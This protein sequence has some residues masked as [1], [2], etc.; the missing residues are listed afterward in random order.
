MTTG[1]PWAVAASVS[2]T[3]Q[4]RGIDKLGE[5]RLGVAASVN[6]TGQARGISATAFA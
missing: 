3:G 6:T 1:R 5:C 4:A 2:T